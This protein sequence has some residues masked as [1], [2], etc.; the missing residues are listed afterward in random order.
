MLLHRH[1]LDN[2]LSV[3]LHP[4]PSLPLVAV[5]LWYHVGSK[6]ERPGRTGLAHLFEHMLFEGSENVGPSRHFH[7]LQLVGG[8]CNGSTS[9]D[10]TNYYETVPAEHLD[11]ALWL[12]ADRMGFLLPAL[13][14]AKL[15]TQ[16]QVVLNERLQRVDNQPYGRASERIFELL[17]PA[18]HPY[19]W[20]VIGYREDVAAATLDELRG[21]FA[22][23]YRPNNAVLTLAGD[24]EAGPA[25]EAVERYFGPIPAGPRPPRPILE[26]GPERT[27]EA[28]ETV[29]DDV[30]LPRLLVAYPAPALGDPDW[31]AADLFST[32]LA[33]GKSSPLYKD[34]VRE[35]QMAQSVSAYVYEH[36]LPGCFLV[37]A[38]ARPGVALE[39]LEERLF[40]LL[41]EARESP[42]AP[43]DLE[44]AKNRTQV[45]HASQL[46]QLDQRADRLSQLALYF[47]DPALLA[48]EIERVQ[49]V[50]AEDLQ[51]FARRWLDPRRR[52]VVSVVPR[53][54]AA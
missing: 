8:V 20:P 42:V 50:T 6:N 14:D 43:A 4:D 29:E 49:A 32:A 7:H 25:L 45:F 2:G 26:A 36:E 34:L 11:L 40:E 18:G 41:E 5:N 24:F 52:A 51:G 10:R 15:D 53:K 44:R 38:S 54:S 21:F 39:A 27:A 28:R 33:D 23:Y 19:R 48:T 13:T 35:R 9:K 12:E 46:Q 31:L 30:Q 3:V 17:Y 1:T 22:T 47:D 37:V 16:R